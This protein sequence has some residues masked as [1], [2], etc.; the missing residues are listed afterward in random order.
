MRRYGLFIVAMVAFAVPARGA[1]PQDPKVPVAAEAGSPQAQQG[2]PRAEGAGG[3]ATPPVAGP[4]A[5]V[6]RYD[7][8]TEDGTPRTA[9][10][11]LEL[12]ETGTRTLGEHVVVDL[13]AA[14][15]G[16]PLPADSLAALTPAPFTTF[17]P[18]ISLVSGRGAVWVIMGDAAAT[19]DV[20]AE[21][22]K[23][24]PTFRTKKGLPVRDKLRVRPDRWQYWRADVAGQPSFCGGVEHPSPDSG[25]FYTS[26]LCY[27]AGTGLTRIA[28]SSVWGTFDIVL[29]ATPNPP[30]K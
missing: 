27:A 24:A 17:A 25:D 3:E 10:M 8:T 16:R 1:P 13:A 19:P 18:A 15:G 22:V 23:T 11:E 5:R 7:V 6:W 12:V 28:F 29:R 26:T 14:R 30:T 20:I 2:A 21:T 4:N 9:T